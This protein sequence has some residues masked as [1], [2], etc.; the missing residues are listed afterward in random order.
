MSLFDNMILKIKPAKE[1]ADSADDSLYGKECLTAGWG[2]TKTYGLRSAV[3]Q[4][5][6]TMNGFKI[7]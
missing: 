3:L 2:L 5:A 6:T 4:K 1:L 7:I